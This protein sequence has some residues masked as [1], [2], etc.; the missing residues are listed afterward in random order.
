MKIS[1][2]FQP[3]KLA[4]WLILVLNALSFMLVWIMQN[5]T[6]TPLASVVLALF[7]LGN[8]GLGAYLTWQLLRPPQV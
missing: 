3:R 1:R 7:A 4:F 2:L 6:L 5:Y 8:A